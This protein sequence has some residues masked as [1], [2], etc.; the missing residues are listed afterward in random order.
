MLRQHRA[1]LV[2]ERA[3]NLRAADVDTDGETR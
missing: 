2:D 1:R 3:E